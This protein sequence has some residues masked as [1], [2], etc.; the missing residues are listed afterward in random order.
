MEDLGRTTAATVD[1]LQALL[2]EDSAQW[3]LKIIKATERPPGTVY[4]ILERLEQRGWVESCWEDRTQ[5]AGPRRRLY[6]FTS[7]GRQ[8]AL[9]TCHAFELRSA[10]R[11]AD[12]PEAR[13][14]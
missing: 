13:L 11:R 12:R 10:T 6:R 1:V 14:A 5:R 3:G 2:S 4:P 7:E 8:A 9:R